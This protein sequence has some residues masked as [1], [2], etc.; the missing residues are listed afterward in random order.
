[1][2]YI[3]QILFYKWLLMTSFFSVLTVIIIKYYEKTHNNLLLLGALLSEAGLI[4]GYTQLLQT[5]DILSQ[6][7]LVKIISVLLLIIPSIVFFGSELTMK[8]IFGLI[9]ALIAI[10]LLK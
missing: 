5:G 3:Q 9:F 2:I 1:M 4:Y 7:S 8:K 10:Y 6:F